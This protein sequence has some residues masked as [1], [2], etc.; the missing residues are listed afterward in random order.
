M[1]MNDDDLVGRLLTRREAV[2]LIGAGGVAALVGWDRASAGGQTSA[3][4]PCVVRPELT[5]GPYFVEAAL[6]RSD[7]RV[8]TTSGLTRDGVPLALAFNLSQATSGRCAP[9]PDAVVHVWQCDA[10]GVYSGVT[11]PRIGSGNLNDNALRGTQ[12]TDAQG[13]ATFT[14]I[15]PGWYRGRAVHIHFKIRTQATGQAYEYTSQLFFP[16]ELTDQIHGQSPYATNGRRDTTND[17]DMIY[18]EGGDQLLLKPT[19][20][21]SGYEAAMNIA[22]D[23]S[24]AAVGRSDAEGTRG[25]GGRGPGRGGRGRSGML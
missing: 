1:S 20:I 19:K 12:T 5:E 24:D 9:L 25:R 3:A 4:L 23:L 15:Y 21:S 16:E 10:V 22:L 8:N 18:R 7:I 6:A 17:R 11:D 14:T 2:R 13:R